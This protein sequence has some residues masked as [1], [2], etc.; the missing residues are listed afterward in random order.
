[1]SLIVGYQIKS[2]ILRKKIWF[3]IYFS[4]WVHDLDSIK[5]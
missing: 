5:N 1:M 2:D 3:C 4:V